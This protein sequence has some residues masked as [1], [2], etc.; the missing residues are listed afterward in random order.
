MKPSAAPRFCLLSLL[1][2]AAAGAAQA[3][4]E[5]SYQKVKDAIQRLLPDA[6]KIAVSETPLPGLLEVRVN[7]DILYVD[8]SGRYL[9]QGRLFD[10]ESRRD[11][12]SNAKSGIRYELLKDVPAEQRITFAPE[13]PKYD[14]TVFTDLD[15]GYCR[16]LHS[17]ID[18][19][20][21]RGIAV[22][23]MSFPRAGRGS[24]S[25]K[26]AESVWCAEDRQKALTRAK[27]G[28]EVEPRQCDNPVGDQFRLGQKI[29]VT[30]TPAIV[31]N[32]GVLIAGYV[33][34]GA[35]QERLANLKQ[36]ASSS[37]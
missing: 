14:V 35:L 21:D 4:P 11:L 30:G 17:Q 8:D 10:I 29:G 13:A 28:K 15:C 6:E 1:T 34:P 23:Y 31:T 36:S 25:F 3:Q 22:H 27:Q 37:R 33:P 2:L 19:Y 26:K 12:T 9:L 16:R 5:P 32:D 20:M 24:A 18:E 7:S